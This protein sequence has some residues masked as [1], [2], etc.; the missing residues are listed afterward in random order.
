MVPVA[1]SEDGKSYEADRCCGGK[2][3]CIP[4][5]FRF[6]LSDSDIRNEYHCATHQY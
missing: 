6:R 4:W 1:I 3:G 5:A 2:Q